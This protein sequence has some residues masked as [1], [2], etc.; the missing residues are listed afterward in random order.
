MR[1][2]QA[3]AA[4]ILVQTM[5]QHDVALARVRAEA[6]ADVSQAKHQLEELKQRGADRAEKAVV[7]IERTVA[8]RAQ[9]DVARPEAR[10]TPSRLGLVELTGIVVLAGLTGTLVGW[11]VS[12]SGLL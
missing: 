10:V 11:L 4:R 7:R 2:E 1:A 6:D 12:L 8:P 3:E 9:V 5:K